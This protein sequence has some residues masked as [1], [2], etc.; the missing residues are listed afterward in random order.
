MILIIIILI[1][2]ALFVYSESYLN[3][4]TLGPDVLRPGEHPPAQRSI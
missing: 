2:G 3:E 4:P 1:G